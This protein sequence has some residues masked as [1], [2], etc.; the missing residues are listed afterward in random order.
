MTRACPNL[1]LVDFDSRNPQTVGH[2][3]FSEA[4]WQEIQNFV[5]S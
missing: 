1:K 5:K 4:A 2:N 3:N